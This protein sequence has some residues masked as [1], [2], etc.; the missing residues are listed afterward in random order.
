MAPRQPMFR[1]P[2]AAPHDTPVRKRGHSH[3][4]NVGKLRGRLACPTRSDAARPDC[5]AS[6]SALFRARVFRAAAPCWSRATV[7]PRPFGA[8][9]GPAARRA[10]ALQRRCPPAAARAVSRC[11][12]ISR[13]AWPSPRR[14][15]FATHT[16]HRESFALESGEGAGSGARGVDDCRIEDASTC[17][18]G[19]SFKNDQREV[20][21]TT[22][23]LQLPCWL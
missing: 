7:A 6:H 20:L 1:R 8:T 19:T 10:V 13:A 5:A 23:L 12:L 3:P 4:G 2:S 18:D 16:C 14:C 21:S 11:G 15:R 17:R 9:R 22:R